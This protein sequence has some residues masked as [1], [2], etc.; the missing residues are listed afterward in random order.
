MNYK[1]LLYLTFIIMSIDILTTY[2]LLEKFCPPFYHCSEA[3]DL[4]NV[5][6]IYSGFTGL[7]IVSVFLLFVAYKYRPVLMYIF[8]ILNTNGSINNIHQISRKARGKLK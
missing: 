6:L 1:K 3:N 2:L 8:I 7:I 4:A 5:V